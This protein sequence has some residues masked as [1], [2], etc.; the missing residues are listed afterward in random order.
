MS[1][2]RPPAGEPVWYGET[3]QGPG[4]LGQFLALP[5]LGVTDLRHRPKGP[6]SLQVKTT[7]AAVLAVRL[8]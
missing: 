1:R 7:Q 5:G 2:K 4:R 8:A 6:A 3:A